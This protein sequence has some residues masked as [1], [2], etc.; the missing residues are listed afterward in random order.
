MNAGPPS[1][2][3]W[4][5]ERPWLAA[6]LWLTPALAVPQDEGT[7][8]PAW[9][10]D[11]ALGEDG[12][13]AAV[14]A[15][16]PEALPALLAYTSGAEPRPGAG[17][18]PS[19]RA[20]V[21]DT[22]AQAP[23]WTLASGLAPLAAP[24]SRF[25]DELRA[26]ALRLLAL[27]AG[28]GELG[29]LTR[30]VHP[31]PA[32]ND[33]EES[34]PGLALRDEYERAL[35]ATLLREPDAGRVLWLGFEGL[36]AVLQPA[37]VRALARAGGDETLSYL[38]EWAG[39][40]REL[41]VFVLH[42]LAHAARRL[43]GDV[44]EPERERLCGWLLSEDAALVAATLPLVSCFREARSAPRLVE[45]LDASDERLRVEARRALETLT[46]RAAGERAADWRRVL[47]DEQRWWAS[48]G[49]A[50]ASVLAVGPASEVAAAIVRLGGHPLF[51]HDL[52]PD[53]GAGLAR[54]EARIVELA[55]AL[56][57]R[58]A[59][60]SVAPDLL[61][62]A[63]EHASPPVR[64]AARHALLALAPELRAGDERAP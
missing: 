22:L 33:P 6:V 34:L 54:D 29:L 11:A 20:L 41:T 28:V 62:L 38:V 56:A 43:P 60:R 30:I 31:D 18:S 46:G 24:G 47:A 58:L 5:A 2:R 1:R 63:H 4:S 32:V 13:R 64:A 16:L 15:A 57:G 55:C 45:L 39:A 52:G 21:R 10:D 17:A 61:A 26:E 53:L 44:G 27:R 59:A 42:Q 37:V 50:A 51:V 14:R 49:R 48:E 35:V 8:V 12:L 40:H 36:P 7:R 9:L 3:G 23:P 25:D 19:R